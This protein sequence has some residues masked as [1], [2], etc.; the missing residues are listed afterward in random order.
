MKVIKLNKQEKAYLS[1]LSFL[2][3][4]KEVQDI[5][6]D[7]FLYATKS[8]M[9]V[10]S[11]HARF[12][13]SYT[14]LNFINRLPYSLQVQGHHLVLVPTDTIKK[15]F[16]KMFEENNISNYVVSTY[17][18]VDRPTF[19]KKYS[20]HKWLT[21]TYDESD[22]GVSSAKGL[23]WCKTLNIP[24]RWKFALSGT[25]G[26][27]N[28]QMLKAKGFDTM[29]D[30]DIDT[31]IAIGTLP[32]FINY[33]LGVELTE[34]EKK[35]YEELEVINNKL[36]IPFRKYAPDG[37]W[38]EYL[39]SIIS[40]R[41]EIIKISQTVDGL[42]KSIIKPAKVFLQELCK[43]TG[44]EKGVF[45]GYKRRYNENR[46]SQNAILENSVNRF[47]VIHE[48]VDYFPKKGIIFNNRKETC[49]I[50]ESENKAIIAHHDSSK[51]EIKDFSKNKDLKAIASVSKLSRG[52]TE[53][54]INYV[55]NSGY[56][57]TSNSYIQKLSRALSMD[58]NSVKSEIPIIN[59][60]C[61]EWNDIVPRDYK[62]LVKSQENQLVQYITS[63]QE[64]IKC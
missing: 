26:Y 52:F 62:R 25:F 13:K 24:S 59:L 11:L 19:N 5:V 16:I 48:L 28:L 38:A 54:C 46:N 27:E 51:S 56:N 14:L 9:V 7:S 10:L 4:R 64:I 30:I 49:D 36:I 15:E 44:W 57:S 1:T 50:L 41:D 35:Q 33:N 29:I 42:P 20:K 12:G 8:K 60:Y 18:A 22:V 21:I 17:Q 53:P 34:L 63:I 37:N 55:I 58:E 47:K 40:D 2:D 3:K 45:L 43:M 31:G 32:S 6:V 39:I 61:K 23:V